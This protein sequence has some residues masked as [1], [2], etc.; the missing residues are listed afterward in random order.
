MNRIS[1]DAINYGGVLEEVE[2]VCEAQ[3]FAFCQITTGTPYEAA[4]FYAH[5]FGY[6]CIEEEFEVYRV[7]YYSKIATKALFEG[8]EAGA[9]L[10]LDWLE[11]RTQSMLSKGLRS[12]QIAR[13]I[14]TVVSAGILKSEEYRSWYEKYGTELLSCKKCASY[15]VKSVL[16]SNFLYMRPIHWRERTYCLKFDTTSESLISLL[17]SCL[18]KLPNES[19]FFV[20]MKFAERFSQ[21]CSETINEVTDFCV[22]SFGEQNDWIREN[23][24]GKTRRR[25]EAFLRQIYC[26]AIETYNELENKFSINAGLTVDMLRQ[27]NIC[28]LWREGFRA[29]VINPKDPAPSFSKWLVLNNADMERTAMFSRTPVHAWN[30]TMPDPF[31]RPFLEW[32]WTLPPTRIP[33]EAKLSVMALADAYES[34]KAQFAIVDG[35]SERP[36]ITSCHVTKAISLYCQGKSASTRS[37]FKRNLEGFLEY[38]LEHRYLSV[39]ES[40]F[41]ILSRTPDERANNNALDV[42]AARLDEL[43]KVAEYLREKASHSIRDTLVYVVFCMQALTPLRLSS[44]LALRVCDLVEGP[45]RGI[46]SLSVSTKSDGMDY[47]SI[48]IPSEVKKLF[49][50]AVETTSPIRDIASDHDRQLL[51]IAETGSRRNGAAPL[52]DFSYRS[53]L[54]AACQA[55]DVPDILPGSVRKRYMTEIVENGAKLNLS[56]LAIKPLT[57]HA[58]EATTNKYY[59]RPDIKEYLEATYGIVIGRPPISGRIQT[60]SNEYSNADLVENGCGFCSRRECEIEG[61]LTCLMCSG[62]VTTPSNMPEIKNAIRSIEH[63]MARVS[64]HDREHLEAV[65]EL[66]VAYL[67]ALMEVS[68]HEQ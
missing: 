60:S 56:K 51:F 30:L 57:G 16:D 15:I 12:S 38:C 52:S 10:N 58:K 2:S 65:K 24:P 9:E 23:V 14:T 33:S 1:Q 53:R 8:V 20:S 68:E 11:E 54:K 64:L 21:S 29:V 22:E 47:R 26:Y 39:E 17:S 28:D 7:R 41:L 36:A 6:D 3:H 4:R 66:Y 63:R 45:R 49:S 37:T 25:A 48:Q 13:S 18:E 34:S 35:N 43:K 19:M 46:W 44:I 62:F 40:V 27:Q 5:Y 50:L 67:G 32:A 59:L 31:Q 42:D 55:V 61:M